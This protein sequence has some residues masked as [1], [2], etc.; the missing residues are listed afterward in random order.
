MAGEK[1]PAD[2]AAGMWPLCVDLDGTLT[3][4]DTLVESLL[5]LTRQRPWLLFS[6]PFW[7][8]QGR[9]AFKAKLMQKAVPNAA[10]LPYNEAVL[11]YLKAEKSRGRE[12]VLATAAHETIARAVASEVGLFTEVLSTS[13]SLNLKGEKKADVLAKRFG[14]DGFAYVGNSSSDIPVW[15]KAAEVIVVQPSRRLQTKI[16][17]MNTKFSTLSA[18]TFRLNSLID[19]LRPHQWAKNILLFVPLVMAHRLSEFNLLLDTVQAFFA[20]SLCASGVYVLNDLLDLE[21]DRQHLH[22]RERPLAA[23]KLPLAWGCLAAPALLVLGLLFSLGL[24]L[25][26]FLILLGYLLLTTSYSFY[27][28]RLLLLDVLVLAALYAWRILAGGVAVGVDISPW[29]ISFSIFIFFSLA[30]LK[31]TTELQALQKQNKLSV[32]GRSYEVVD[33][34]QLM[35]FGSASGYLAVL[36]FALYLNSEQVFKLYQRPTL[37]WFICPLIL[38]W[39]SRVWLIGHRGH[40]HTDPVVFVIKDRVS[41]LLVLAV[42]IILIA[43]H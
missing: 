30:L 17:R 23:G 16:N 2:A 38:Y 13:G 25:E 19:S 5:T 37:L 32:V 28:K 26:F 15:E 43:A 7:L 12:L 11:A 34:S 33:F 4:S 29:L 36:V 14:Q 18:P 31:R 35:S 40:L 20:F 10:L 3:T 22:K 42:I 24:P 27:F 39:V 9:A 6:L 21:S 41:Y 1:K 8:L